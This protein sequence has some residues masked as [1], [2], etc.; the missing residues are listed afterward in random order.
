MS[1]A[2]INN[3]GSILSFSTNMV[4]KPPFATPHSVG[5]RSGDILIRLILAEDGIDGP[6]FGVN[7]A[8]MFPKRYFCGMSGS[9][10]HYSL[11]VGKVAGTLRLAGS[12]RIAKV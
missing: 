3:T 5:D 11:H 2:D 9:S 7:A 10:G 1:A 4:L 8:S 6:A 12:I